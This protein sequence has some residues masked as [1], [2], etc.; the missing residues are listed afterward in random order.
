MSDEGM[1]IQ[2]DFSAV[3]DVILPL[4]PAI[5]DFI[6]DKVERKAPNPKPDGSVSLGYN[7][8]A[9]LRVAEG[10]QEG[11][12]ITDYIWISTDPTLSKEE[13]DRNLTGIKRFLKAF[14]VEVTPQGANPM[15]AV[16]RKAK[17]L[18]KADVYK[19]KET[20]RLDKYFIPGD[21]EL[22]TAPA[23]SA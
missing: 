12:K 13:R 17:A 2:A 22:S 11:R 9:S 14:G 10:P 21:P 8:V 20:S 3:P 1:L 15:D 5:Y 6:C 23:I 7:V 16:G 19:G 4:P 18:V